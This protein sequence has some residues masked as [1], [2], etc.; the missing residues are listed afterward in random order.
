MGAP[1]LAV[2][3]DESKGEVEADGRVDGRAD[4]LDGPARRQPA[5]GGSARATRWTC[6]SCAFA[7]V[8]DGGLCEIC[9]TASWTCEYCTYDNAASD[10]VCKVCRA[11]PPGAV[12]ASGVPRPYEESD[13]SWMCA[14]C[15]TRHNPIVT[16]C[17][18]C[19]RVREPGEIPPQFGGARA[20]SAPGARRRPPAVSDRA[21]D[22]AHWCAHILDL[23]RLRALLEPRA[24]ARR[25]VRVLRIPARRNGAHTRSRLLRSHLPAGSRRQPAGPIGA[26]TRPRPAP[27]NPSPLSTL[28]TSVGATHGANR[29]EQTQPAR[30]GRGTARTT[31]STPPESR[32]GTPCSGIQSRGRR[33]TEEKCAR[34][35]WAAGGRGHARG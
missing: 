18:A 1:T 30:V 31:T 33:P 7:N 11:S 3:G 22:G 4:G 27:R 21:G 29:A 9:G 17:D 20:Q 28:R 26:H 12:D 24:S 32:A 14:E 16:R 5:E 10:T 34:C 35:L 19:W 23:H 13:H 8:A 15:H 2:P 6:E 25:R